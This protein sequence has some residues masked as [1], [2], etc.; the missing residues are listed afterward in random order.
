MEHEIRHAELEALLDSSQVARLLRIPKRTVESWRYHRRGPQFVRLSR[1][2]IRYSR[3][4]VLAWLRERVV[5][6]AESQAL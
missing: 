6:P 3:E 2:C 1:Q 5:A 4:D